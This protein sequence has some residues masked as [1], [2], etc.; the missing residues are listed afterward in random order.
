MIL[1]RTATS[2]IFYVACPL[3]GC[4]LQIHVR[5]VPPT[6]TGQEWV[7]SLPFEAQEHIH[8]EHTGPVTEPRVRTRRLTA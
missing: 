6:T 8:N 1:A 4:E 2:R 5:G 3:C 7:E